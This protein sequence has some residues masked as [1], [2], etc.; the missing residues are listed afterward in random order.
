MI[1]LKELLKGT[2][3]KSIPKEHQDNLMILLERINKVRS[4]YGKPMSVT[5]PYRS[6]ADHLRIYK[7]KGITDQ[8]KIPMKSKHLFGQAVDISD[9]NQELQKWVKD[10]VKLMEEFQ[11]WMEDFSATKNWVHFQLVPPKSG[12]RFFMP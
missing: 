1:T 9:P 11:L 8:S 3:F 10:N 7:E 12:K 2:D 5:S 4:A 6:M